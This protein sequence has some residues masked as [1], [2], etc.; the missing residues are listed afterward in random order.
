MSFMEHFTNI[1][2]PRVDIDVKH[3]LP[4]ALFLTISAVLSG[5]ESWK[6]IKEFGDDKLDW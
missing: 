6:D 1:T 3:D 5:T 4:D 2:D